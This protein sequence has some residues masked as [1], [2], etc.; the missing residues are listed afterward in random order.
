MRRPLP[1]I[2]LRLQTLTNLSVVCWLAMS[3]GLSNINRW[4]FVNYPF[5]Y[6]IL[7]TTLHVLSAFLFGSYVI[8]FTPMGAAFG[9]GSERLKLPP[10]LYGKVFILSIVFSASIAC[11]NIALRYLYV[12]FVKM[13]SATTPLV[14]V[15]LYRMMFNRNF[16][17]FVNSSMVPLCFGSML[18]TVGEVNFSALGFIAALMST[19][20]RGLKSI[21]QGEF[22]ADLA[23][24]Q[25]SVIAHKCYHIMSKE[26]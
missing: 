21:L 10:S 12:S 25:I 5:D 13:I 22:V 4:I 15:V 8:R 14:T 24:N 20:L 7:L 18:C 2:P 17:F 6:P 3:I 19:V 1:I 9:E 23:V 11:G 26:L 16:D